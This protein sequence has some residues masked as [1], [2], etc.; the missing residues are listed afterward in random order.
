[1][2]SKNAVE[3]TKEAI[4]TLQGNY[5]LCHGFLGNA[6]TLLNS[7]RILSI[8]DLYST[9]INKV[10][11]GIESFENKNLPWPC[12]TMNSVSDPSLMI[13]EAGIGHFILRVLDES[14]PS[15]LCLSLNTDVEQDYS[16]KN[17]FR[18]IQ[19]KYISTYFGK[20]IQELSNEDET[21]L[22]NT[23]ISN[24][25]QNCSDVTKCYFILEQL[26]SKEN[27]H[28]KKLLEANFYI[29]KIKYLLTLGINDFTEDYLQNHKKPTFPDIKNSNYHLRLKYPTKVIDNETIHND[30]VSEVDR[31]LLLYLA[32]NKIQQKFINQLTFIVLKKLE[33]RMSFNQ[34][35]Q[36]VFNEFEVMD[37]DEEHTLIQI[38]HDQLFEAYKANL[39]DIVENNG[40]SEIIVEKIRLYVE[41]E[42]DIL[43][44]SH[45]ARYKLHQMLRMFDNYLSGEDI[46]YRKYQLSSI[47]EEIKKSL[48]ILNTLHFFM[49]RLITYKKTNDETI[50]KSIIEEIKT[51]YGDTPEYFIIEQ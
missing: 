15:V 51:I 34:V 23:F 43:L 33:M 17:A 10:I 7:S 47:L 8:R 14:V 3:V 13:G 35:L 44:S 32:D 16:C 30:K 28:N 48:V 37:E 4:N 6:E 50:V 18:Q 27:T 22:W 41:D 25:E 5:S 21:T 20:T 12:G 1:M 9:V 45:K 36:E 31:F 11:E 39:I 26:I 40:F 46:L 24:N 42:F 29:E 49:P 19:R 2:E 38:I